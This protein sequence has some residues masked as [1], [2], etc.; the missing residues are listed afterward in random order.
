M[1]ERRNGRR[2]LIRRMVDVVWN[3]GE[4]TAWGRDI[5]V[6]G[7]YVQSKGCPQAGANV[8]L[9]VRFRRAPTVT[10]PAQ[11]CWTDEDGFAVRFV[12]LGKFETDTIKQ[13]I[14]GG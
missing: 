11:V 9:M 12:G 8:R 5:G 6:G 4:A 3:D 2:V 10:I 13:V 1:S 7:M 14:E